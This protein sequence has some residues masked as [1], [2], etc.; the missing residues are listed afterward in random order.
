MVAGGEKMDW[1][2]RADGHFGQRKCVVYVVFRR[3]MM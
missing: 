2:E 1:M 3:M